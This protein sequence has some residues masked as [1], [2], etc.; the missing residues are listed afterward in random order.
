MKKSFIYQIIIV[1]L[2]GA[3][4]LTL[5]PKGNRVYEEYVIKKN[6]E[7]TMEKIK[8][9]NI[10]RPSANNEE[11]KIEAEN[12]DKTTTT[13]ENLTT[14][15]SSAEAYLEVQF[16]CQA[17]LQ[18]EEN[19]TLHE[20]SCE[21]AALLQA[22]LYTVGEEMTREEANEK[23]LD[24]I[25]WQEENMGGHHDLY[26]EE[27]GEFIMGYYELKEN[28]IRIIKNA[29]IEDIKTE[30]KAGHPV[31]API[32]GEILQNPYYPYPGYH[33]L[34]IIGF[35]EDRIITND[36]GTR[37]GADFSYDIEIFEE[38][39]KDASGDLIILQNL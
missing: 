20:E 31:I 25:A 8:E 33:M 30:I 24:M 10:I 21:E 16:I 4:L 15:T 6:N 12:G 38:A 28:Q 2:I 23:I 29:T 1:L 14:N 11:S 7:K 26:S 3:A 32:T 36:N 34:T 35:T 37:N 18:T 22:Y 39:Y 27:M 9:S 13:K 17:P 5:A 19:W